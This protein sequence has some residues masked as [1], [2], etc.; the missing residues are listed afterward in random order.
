MTTQGGCFRR[1]QALNATEAGAAALIVGYPDLGPAEIFRPTL[2][3]PDGREIPVVS[4]TGEAVA[5]IDEAGDAEVALSVGTEREPTTARNVVAQLGDGDDVVML[6]GHLDSV[7]EGPG[8][9]DNGS[10]VASLL[11]IARGIAAAGV[12]DGGAVRIGLWAAEELGTVGSRAYVETLDDRPLAYLNLDMTGSPN[13]ATL[14]YDEASAAQ[15]S[16]TITAA[17]QAWLDARGETHEP[18]DIRG[19]SDH[20]GFVQAGIPTGGLFAGASLS[21]SAA[22]PGA[23]GAGTAPDPCYHLACDD[24]DNVD[25]DRAALFADATFAVAYALLASPPR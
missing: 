24:L 7:F 9:N 19:S 1:Q 23:G 22:Q 20:F 14:V 11:E 2:I 13:G 6:G 5:A 17:Y 21:G 8:I 4:V 15:G 3:D 18:V 10:G 16:T 12:P 25:V